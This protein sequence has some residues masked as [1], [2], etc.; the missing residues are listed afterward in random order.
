MKNTSSKETEFTGERLIPNAPG[1]KFLYQ[2]H[3]TRYIFASSFVKNKIVLD[4]ACGT[5]YGSSF[6]V[7]HDASEVIGIDNADDAILHC[8]ENYSNPKLSFKKADCLNLPFE[9]STFDTTVSFETIEHLENPNKFLTEIK[10]ILK[11]DGV[12]IVST[13]NIESYDEENPFHEHE[14]S[15]KD[16][17]SILHKNF[18]NVSI[19]FQFYPS[20]IMI[21]NYN[22]TTSFETTI[23]DNKIN[24]EIEP[25][26]FI[27]ICSDYDLPLIPNQN[28]VFK[29]SN[30]IAGKQSHLKELRERNT[31]NEAHLKEFQT[32]E[33]KLK[34]TEEKLQTTEETIN[35]IHQSF[36]WKFLQKYDQ[37][38]KKLK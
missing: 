1:L 17:E 27:A 29:D 8:N 4:A 28:F 11:N 12:F 7:E 16:F 9:D 5:G 36:T 19:F 13:P 10:R 31:A 35:K 30:L 2:E 22:K 26:Y 38:T 3:I 34:T 20:S 15:L 25:L 23:V 14:F 18:K 6:L 33:K 24:D 21:G 32:T 37:L